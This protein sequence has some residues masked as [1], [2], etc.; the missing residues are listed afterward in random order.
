[1]QHCNCDSCHTTVPLNDSMIILGEHLC[2]DCARKVADKNPDLT[3]EDVTRNPDPTVCVNC[4]HDGGFQRLEQL[5]ELPFCGTCL[6]LIG[7]RPFPGW[8][9]I[10]ALVLAVLVVLSLVTNWRFIQANSELEQVDT[11]IAAGDAREVANLFASAAG[12]APEAYD[13]KI[14]TSY[15]TGIALVSEDRPEEAITE[16]NKCV[17]ELPPDFQVAE[18]I[19]SARSGAAFDR[20][21][22]REFL[23]LVEIQA[24]DN[25]RDLTAIL[26]VASALACLYVDTGDESYAHRAEAII[27]AIPERDMDPSGEEYLMRIRHRLESRTIIG[28]QEFLAQYPNGWYA[29]GE[30]H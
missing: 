21:D 18:M 12:H 28:S 25:P 2:L 15:W 5:M 24:D 8:I 23:R 22:Y 14:M 9:K 1:M 6:P 19:S 26:S 29:S 16:F 27:D 7:N 20:H 13:L 11:A 3:E 4:G 10:S 17:N 30:A